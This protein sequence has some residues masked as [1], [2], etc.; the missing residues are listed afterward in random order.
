MF[1]VALLNLPCLWGFE[2][3]SFIVYFHQLK[4]QISMYKTGTGQLKQI[5]NPNVE[6]AVFCTLRLQEVLLNNLLTDRWTLKILE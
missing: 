6:K 2:S 5:D 1:Y 3:H 4:V